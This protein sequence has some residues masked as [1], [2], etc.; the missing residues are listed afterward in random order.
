MATQDWYPPPHD[1]VREHSSDASTRRIDLVTRAGLEEVGDS[2]SEIRSRL[3]ELDREWNLD[4]AL[5]LTFSIVGGLTARATMRSLKQRGRYGGWGLFFW[6]QIGFMAHH[7]IRGWCPPVELLRRM[8]FR[9]AREIS[10]E[11]VTLARR[12]SNED[13]G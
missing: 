1:D 7:A 5:M 13:G 9:T 11:R 6:T 2:P 8:G 12:L 3:A 10:A 4:R